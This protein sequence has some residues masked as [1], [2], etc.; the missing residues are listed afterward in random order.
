MTELNGSAELAE[1]YM[2]VWNEPDPQARRSAVAQIWSED[3]RCC[4]PAAD[5]VGLEAI[6][7][8][9]A[10]AHD[11]WV[12]QGGFVF[13]PRGAVD[14]HHGGMRVRWD[15]VPSA[16]GEPVS[17]GVQFLLLG[18]DGRVRYDYQFIDA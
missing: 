13:R 18:D 15:M 6:D 8:R 9:V 11:K 3:A 12:G 1:R 7:G 4:T 14:E 16:G 17:S 2:A 10:A 5:Y